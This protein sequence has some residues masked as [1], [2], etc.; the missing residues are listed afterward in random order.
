MRL[1]GVACNGVFNHNK[2]GIADGFPLV[3]CE[4][5]SVMWTTIIMTLKL[6]SAKIALGTPGQCFVR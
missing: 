4:P 6:L 2:D 1:E 5:E 3:G